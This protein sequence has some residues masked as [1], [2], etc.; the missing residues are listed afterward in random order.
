MSAKQDLIIKLHEFRKLPSKT[1]WFEF[2]EA[3]GNFSTNDIV[4]ILMNYYCY[5]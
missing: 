3:N 2:K 1:E 5:S 4:V